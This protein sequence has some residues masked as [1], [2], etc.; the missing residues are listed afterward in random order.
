M[1]PGQITNSDALPV[2]QYRRTTDA[3]FGDTPWFAWGIMA[4][5][6]KHALT[7]APADR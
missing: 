1:P 2:G 4:R 7:I 6:G 5:F 3:P